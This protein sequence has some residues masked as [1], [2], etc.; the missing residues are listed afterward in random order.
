MAHFA[1]IDDQNIVLRVL[2]TDNNDPKGDE[3]YQFLIDNFGGTW[4][5]TSYNG[6]IRYNYAAIGYSY[7]P[8]DDA[9]IAP[10]P[11]CGHDELLLNDQKRWEC[12]NDEHT[13]QIS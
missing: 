6:T 4:V 11:E 8:I 3:G 5:K 7:D 13:I 12:S 9:F 1:E 2:V 10:M